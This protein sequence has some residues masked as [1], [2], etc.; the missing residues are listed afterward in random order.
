MLRLQ[1][2]AERANL[3]AE[4]IALKSDELARRGIHVSEL[5]G[6]EDAAVPEDAAAPDAEGS[7]PEELTPHGEPEE[8]AR[9]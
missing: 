3:A 2:E 8:P 9:G 5:G 4:T 1:L 6:P 7:W